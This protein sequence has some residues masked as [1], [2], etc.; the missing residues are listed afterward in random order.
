MFINLLAW[1]LCSS[2]ESHF[3]PCWAREFSGQTKCICW[4]LATLLWYYGCFQACIILNWS[5][6]D[7]SHLTYFA[8]YHI[9]CT[10]HWLFKLT[11][12]YEQFTGRCR[13]FWAALHKTLCFCFLIV[14][15]SVLNILFIWQWNSFMF[16]RYRGWLARRFCYILFVQE[17]DVHK[18]MF[19]KNLTENVLNNCR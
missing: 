8:L 18:G 11:L 17:R 6:A 16:C 1:H 13:R 9:L 5:N 10:I 7:I 12:A 3:S 2:M 14:L 4:F 15:L 19:A